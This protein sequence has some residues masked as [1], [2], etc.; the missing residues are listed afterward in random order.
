MK[1]QP[2]PVQITTEATRNNTAE[3]HMPLSRIQR[4]IGE[5]ML[6]SKHSKP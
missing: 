6:A 4:L 5:R 1:R 3:T 2:I